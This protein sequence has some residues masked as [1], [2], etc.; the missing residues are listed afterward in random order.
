MSDVTEVIVVGCHERQMEKL[1]A[2]LR[3]HDEERKQQFVKI[4]MD[5]AGGMMWYVS[6]VWAAAFNYAPPGLGEKLRDPETWGD[7]V[8]SIHVILD[9]EQQS[10]AFVFDGDDE[11]GF[12][13]TMRLSW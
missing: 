4:N 8:L 5:A 13:P 11:Q 2:W 10:E 12:A 7:D 6:D 3:E 1:N 9:G